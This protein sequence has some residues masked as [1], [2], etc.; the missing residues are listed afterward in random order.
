MMHVFD[1]I[2][3]IAFFAITF[4][5]A[6]MF[7]HKHGQQQNHELAVKLAQWAVAI[8]PAIAEASPDPQE[9][10]EKLGVC[11][12]RRVEPGSPDAEREGDDAEL[13]TT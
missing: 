3:A 4:T 5:T 1:L 11:E 13:C 2:A 10:G 12:L 6:W 7:G 8:W 9:Y